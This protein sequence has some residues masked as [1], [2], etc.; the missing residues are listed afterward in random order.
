MRRI[1]A[2]EWAEEA[3]DLPY[4]VL[5]PAGDV[6]PVSSGAISY[7]PARSI[8][9]CRLS[10]R[11]SLPGELRGPS[12]GPP[13]PGHFPP[14]HTPKSRSAFSAHCRAALA[15]AFTWAGVF[16]PFARL[17]S[18]LW[19]AFFFFFSLAPGGLCAA[20]RKPAHLQVP[21]SRLPPPAEPPNSSHRQMLSRTVITGSFNRLIRVE[22]NRG[23]EGQSSVDSR[24]LP[25]FVP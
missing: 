16:S 20:R 10:E 19:P 14:S 17:L 5:P 18:A 1:R 23:T 8:W 7:C 13:P 3:H 21:R 11:E 4:A 9:G 24:R 22:D 12:L 25:V 6:T 15:P 2:E